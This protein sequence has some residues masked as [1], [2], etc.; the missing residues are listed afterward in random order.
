MYVPEPTMTNTK[1]ARTYGGTTGG[2]S[3]FCSRNERTNERTNEL[4]SNTP[5]QQASI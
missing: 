3:F 1:M 2:S 5:I 4:V